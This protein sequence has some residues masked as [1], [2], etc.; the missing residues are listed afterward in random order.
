[1]PV[2]NNNAERTLFEQIQQLQERLG[3]NFEGFT[4]EDE[5]DLNI[6]SMVSRSGNYQKKYSEDIDQPDNANLKQIS[7]RLVRWLL[8]I[9]KTAPSWR[10]CVSRSRISA[11][12]E[13]QKWRLC[14]RMPAVPAWISCSTTSSAP[15]SGRQRTN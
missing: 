2:G 6:Y 12:L 13:K 7:K 1:M 9:P 8:I 3:Q 5:E 4:N 11:I 10:L 15:K 14:G